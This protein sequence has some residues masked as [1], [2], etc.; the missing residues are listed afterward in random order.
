MKY[1][2]QR[3]YIYPEKRL[4]QCPGC[5]S[6][7]MWPIPKDELGS[8]ECECGQ[9]LTRVD[10]RGSETPPLVDPAIAAAL[11]RAGRDRR[12]EKGVVG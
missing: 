10:L 1:P 4:Y 11:R 3:L 12:F 8:L 7:G 5:W 9:R 2:R 6:W